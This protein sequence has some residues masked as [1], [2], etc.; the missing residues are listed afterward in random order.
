MRSP[1]MYFRCLS[2][3]S[4]DQGHRYPRLWY[5]GTR[6]VAIVVGPPSKLHARMASG[7]LGQI[8]REASKKQGLS[9]EVKDRLICNL[10][11]EMGNRRD[12]TTR[13]VHYCT[14]TE[15]AVF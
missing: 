14:W 3:C 12:P 4:N 1:S 11:T 9:E 13:T 7:L 5:D 15:S 6:N 8:I 2:L 10:L